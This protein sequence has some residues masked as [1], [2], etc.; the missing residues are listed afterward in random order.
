MQNAADGI[1]SGAV[2]G[3]PFDPDEHEARSADADKRHGAET[4]GMVLHTAFNTDRGPERE[5]QSDP[6]RG[7]DYLVPL[8][9]LSVPRPNYGTAAGSRRSHE[10]ASSTART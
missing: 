7:L 5:R 6:G 2:F 3:E 8:H 10:Y 9:V 4:R 1:G